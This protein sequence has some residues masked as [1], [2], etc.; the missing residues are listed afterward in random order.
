MINVNVF[1]KVSKK[2][3]H[4][5][6]TVDHSDFV[7]FVFDFQLKSRSLNKIYTERVLLTESFSLLFGQMK[8]AET[9]FNSNKR[10]AS[11]LPLPSSWKYSQIFFILF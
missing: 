3:D 5:C 8:R 6:Q 1:I 7:L 9:Q 4:Q 11:T 2:H 10:Q